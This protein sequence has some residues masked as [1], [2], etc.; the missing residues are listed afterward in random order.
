[1]V[2]D[3]IPMASSNPK[4]F[5]KKKRVNR[6][7]KLKQCKLD[8]RREQ[9]LSQVKNRGS[10]EEPNGGGGACGQEG[11]HA[12][13]ERGKLIEK[14]A[15]QPRGGGEEEN[16][17][18]MN[19]YSDFDS[20]SNCPTSHTSS[21]LE[22]ND[23]GTN[24]IGGSSSSSSGGGCCSGSMSEEDNE[25]DDGCLDDWEAVADALAANDKKQEQHNSSLD[26]APERD[27]NVVHMSS[28]PEFSDRN[29]S[30]TD[31]SQ[32]KSKAWRPDDAFRPQSLPNLSKHFTFPMNSGW[33]YR[34]GSIWGCKS[35]SISTSCPICC[36]DLDFTD[37]SF[38]PCP[39][40][41][42]LCLFCHKRIL[43]ED[44]RCPGCRKQ[45]K[46]DPVEGETTKDAGCLMFR[47][48]RS[49]SMI[50]RS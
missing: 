17:G 43:E 34:G 33:H 28:Q 3:S 50:S 6:S 14:L 24:F 30:G 20:P 11:M 29:V 32:P 35:L 48:A 19:H 23:S 46:H 15:I 10:K 40:G 44:G 42:R 45:Y 5:S 22:G 31:M 7:A 41:F 8:A 18:C 36:E 25:G 37:T 13:N 16:G 12:A 4:D 27:D 2:S 9:W 47:P 26:S 38:L 49:C 1:M 39:C 21:V